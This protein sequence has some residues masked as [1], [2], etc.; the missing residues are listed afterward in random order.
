MKIIFLDIDGVLNCE[1]GFENGFC[2]FNDDYGQDFYPPS[3]DLINQLIEE[4]G[5]KVVISST[6][7][8]SG[9]KTMKQMWKDRKMAGEVIGIT[10][11]LTHINR[12][13]HFNG[14]EIHANPCRGEEIDVW[15]KS[16]NFR[17]CFWSKENQQQH[18]DESGIENFIIID[19]D[20]D[21]LYNQKYH[22]VHVLPSPRNVDGFHVGHYKQA[23][24]MLEKSLLELY[25]YDG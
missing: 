5:A 12:T 6:W 2:Q 11:S 4:T 15:L 23:K 3:A 10:P 19:D 16:K 1:T 24:E 20:S 21:M 7:R 9:E 8:H 25:G 17:Q 18:I 13:I 22:F 14:K